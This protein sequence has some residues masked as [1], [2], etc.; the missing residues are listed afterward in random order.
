MVVREP[1]YKNG[2]YICILPKCWKSLLAM[3]NFLRF[4]S[5]PFGWEVVW[6][7][8]NQRGMVGFLKKGCSG[9]WLNQ[10]L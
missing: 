5:A 9:W 3:M 2:G 6:G 7:P 10:P 8:K 1:T 4:E